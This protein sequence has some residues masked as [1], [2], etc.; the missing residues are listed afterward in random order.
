MI[1]III[2][3]NK[4]VLD[5]IFESIFNKSSNKIG[6]KILVDNDLC[7]NNLLTYD[8]VINLSI[9]LNKFQKVNH[10][11]ISNLIHNENYIK[12]NNAFRQ[13]LDTSDNYN[14]IYDIK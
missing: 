14:I 12:F 5:T 9:G 8:D 3:N 2:S 7:F 11:I 6:M 1:K 4:D 13:M 10:E